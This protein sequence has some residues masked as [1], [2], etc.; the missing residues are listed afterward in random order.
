MMP[1]RELEIQR[2]LGEAM[3]L[4]VEKIASHRENE[5]GAA[6]RRHSRKP[7]WPR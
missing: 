4:F 3:M 5:D 6:M 2:K 7:H 1:E